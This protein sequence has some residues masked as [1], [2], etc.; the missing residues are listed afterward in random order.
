MEHALKC[1]KLERSGGPDNLSPEHL[2]FCGPVCT[3]WLCKAYNS[4][5]DLEQ[6]PDCFKHGI[7]VPAFKGKGRDPLHVNS[8]RGITL[9]SVLAKVLEILLL[10]Q[11]SV[12]LD[13][14]EV[15][16][17]TQTAYRRNVGCRDSIFASQEV[18]HKFINE[19]DSVYTCYYD[20]E[21]AF[22]TVEFCVLLEQLVHVGIRGKCWRL[23]KNWHEDF[24]TEVR[25]IPI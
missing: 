16:Q 8:Y 20:L 5:C 14:S 24:A 7:I 1:L 13:E 3:N 4:I 18:N 19:G 23:I 15:P 22:D 17:L 25:I 12:I 6:I 9:T 10:N 21:K 2:R 11:M